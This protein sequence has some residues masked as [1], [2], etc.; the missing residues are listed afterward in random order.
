MQIMSKTSFFSKTFTDFAPLPAYHLAASKIVPFTLQ[1]STDAVQIVISIP[2]GGFH[3]CEEIAQQNTLYFERMRS[4]EDSGT[5]LLKDMIKIDNSAI[6]SAELSR[7]L[8]DLNRPATALDPQLYDEDISRSLPQDRFARYIQAGYG[9]APRLCA[10]KKSLYEKRL[11]VK[12]TQKLID[13]FHKP[14][15]ETLAYLLA[16]GARRYGQVILLDIHSMPSHYAGKSCPDFVFGDHFGRCLPAI[17][18]EAITE[19]MRQLGVSCGWNHPYAGGYITT[20][21]GDIHGPVYAMQIEINRALYTKANQTISCDALKEIAQIINQLAT[22][23][24][25]HLSPN[26]AAE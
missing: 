14:Y 23:L 1:K 11:S 4:L 7:A 19:R 2:H 21:Y 16:Q 13:R 20:H 24:K 25:A 17:M 15:H 26:I 5:S 10:Q 18:R 9:V 8:I 12:S 3:Y 22:S 6:I